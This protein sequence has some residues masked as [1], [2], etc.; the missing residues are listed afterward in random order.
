MF[1]MLME[2]RQYCKI[3][4]IFGQIFKNG[5]LYKLFSKNVT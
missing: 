4:A 2:T 3:I 5:E 1:T